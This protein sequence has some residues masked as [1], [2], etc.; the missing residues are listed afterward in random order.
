MP[1]DRPPPS[2]EGAR[3]PLLFLVADTGG[4]HRASARAVAR[5]LLAARGAAGFEIEVL[6]P[7]AASQVWAARQVPVAY[8]PLIRVAPAAWG[9]VWHA[10]NSR[11]AVAALRSSLGR[12]VSPILAERMTRLRP[13]VVVSFHPLL[14]HVAATV[15]H[16]PSHPI[17]V[18]T[19]ITD[20]SSVHASWLCPEVD[21]VVAPSPSVLDRCRRA[22]IPTGRCFDYGLPVDAAFSAQAR[23]SLPQRAALRRRLGL[24]E[25]AFTMLVVGGGDGSGSLEAR[26]RAVVD[27]GVDA[28][29]LVVCGHNA[30]LRRRLR[31]LRDGRGRPVAVHGFVDNMAELTRAADV[32]VSK[33]GP[34]T[35]A[36]SLC[37]GVPLLLT[38]HVPG[39]ERHNVAYVL[40]AG[41][42]RYVPRL[43]DLVDTVAELAAPG[44]PGLAALRE[45]ARRAARPEATE[46]IAELIATHAEGSAA[47]GLPVR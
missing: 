4:G 16:A 45:R 3:V 32:V 34:G 36:E 21:A 2:G 31:G 46:R 35:I 11:A 44:S 5:Q 25:E 38:W 7:F 41:A 12:L 15:G 8:G 42:G 24:A 10:T 17:P 37:C 26:V 6:D 19:V 22:G 9:A 39:Q 23:L 47:P 33:A 13:A 27:A 20:L 29:L 18:I 1:A 28:Q 14:N 30:R 43:R 40:A